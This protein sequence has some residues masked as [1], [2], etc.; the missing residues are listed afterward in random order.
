MKKTFLLSL[1][2][3]TGF[4]NAY[5]AGGDSSTGGG[6]GGNLQ[7]ATGYHEGALDISIFSP[8]TGAL[9]YVLKYYMLGGARKHT[10]TDGSFS[11][12]LPNDPSAILE[13]KEDDGFGGGAPG[14]DISASSQKIILQMNM[15]LPFAQL[16]E[17]SSG[18]G[19]S[20][21]FFHGITAETLYRGMKASGIAP[22]GWTIDKNGNEVPQY[23]DGSLSCA[24]YFNPGW[25][26][27]CQIVL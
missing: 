18:N 9:S 17:V 4:A 27:G 8:K 26:T 14:A 16:R 21:I 24:V 15:V 2:L 25:G 23:S 13:Y 22:S 10:N 5:A 12:S 20:H 19:T 3:L 6:G 1:M 7:I 11:Y